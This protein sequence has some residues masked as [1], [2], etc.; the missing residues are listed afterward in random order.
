MRG[1]PNS[2]VIVYIALYI[3]GIAGSALCREVAS[4]KRFHC[5]YITKYRQAHTHTLVADTNYVNSPNQT[6]NKQRAVRCS[7]APGSNLEVMVVF[8]LQGAPWGP[9]RTFHTR[10]MN[11]ANSSMQL[12]STHGTEGCT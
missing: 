7:G 1:V 9:C 4:I 3:A 2:D 6:C 5:K 12:A 11:H 10:S 8:H